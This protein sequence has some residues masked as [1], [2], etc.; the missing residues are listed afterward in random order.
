MT[1]ARELGE[2]DYRSDV[3]VTVLGHI[4][5]Q[6][7]TDLEKLR[8]EGRGEAPPP[9][10]KRKREGVVYTPDTVTRFLVERTLGL[11]LAERFSALLATMPAS[12]PCRRTGR[13]HSVA[14]WRG[15]DAAFWRDY[16]KALRDLTVVDPACG[17]GA[18]LVAAFDLLARSIAR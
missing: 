13:H 1:G 6:S 5:E 4:F 18:F 8:A 11:T 17:S 12:A 14:R 2:W 9:F 3:P 16:L 15:S 10:R 7:I